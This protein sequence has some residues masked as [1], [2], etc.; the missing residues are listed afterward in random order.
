MRSSLLLL[1]LSASF[2]L[3]AQQT[4]VAPHTDDA[5]AILEGPQT[6]GTAP[7][8][9]TS[10]P[11]LLSNDAIIRMHSAGLGDDLILQTIAAQPGRYDTSADALIALK[12]AGISSEVMSAMISKPVAKV[13]RQ[14]SGPPPA[15]PITLSPVNEIGC[16]YKDSTGRWQPMESEPIHSKSSGWIKNTLSDGIIKQDMNGLVNGPESKLLLPR[17]IEFLIYT[18]DGVNAGEYTLIRFRLNGKDRQFR[19]LTGGVFHSTG[20]A[21]DDEV[22][23]TAKKI[24]PRTWVFTLGRDTP[25]AEYG[26]LPPGT[27]NVTNGGKIY[28][29][30]I[31]E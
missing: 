25:G 3:N 16:Y 4:P 30:A 26:I 11:V 9:R 8:P 13:R 20:G 28:T 21:K 1:L 18:A 12:Q 31:S 17:P 29:F 19:T 15:D 23:F 7:A 27:G 14:I 5:P 22:P 2:S 10:E 24:A 6:P